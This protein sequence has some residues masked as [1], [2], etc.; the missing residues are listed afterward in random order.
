MNSLNIR[1]EMR[2]DSLAEPFL[3][4]PADEHGALRP[5]LHDLRLGGSAPKYFGVI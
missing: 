2:T 4:F 5:E 3:A 1:K